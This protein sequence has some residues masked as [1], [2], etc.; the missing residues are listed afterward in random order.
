MNK[1]ELDKYRE[2]YSGW[3]LT[4]LKANLDYARKEFHV[5]QSEESAVRCEALVELIKEKE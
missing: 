4:V 1:K 5:T 2:L 3:T